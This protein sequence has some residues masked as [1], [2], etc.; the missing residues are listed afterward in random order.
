MLTP[1]V[2]WLLR[3]PLCVAIGVETANPGSQACSGAASLSVSLSAQLAG[4]LV[5]LGVAGGL[6]VWQLLALDRAARAGESRAETGAPARPAS[7]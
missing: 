3:A 5:V 2:M 7:A 1:V 4:I 6:L